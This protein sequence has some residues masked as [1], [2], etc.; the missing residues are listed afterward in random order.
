MTT[1]ANA[2]EI[3]E[4]V[5]LPH[6]DSKKL[7]GIEPT[8]IEYSDMTNDYAWYRL[9][10]KHDAHLGMENFRDKDVYI[11]YFLLSL[12]LLEYP[13]QL[14]GGNPGGGKSLY[15]AWYTRQCVRL[16][17]KKATL[18]WVPPRPEL[19]GDFHN[20]Y[21]QDFIDEIM[22]EFDRLSILEKECGGRIPQEEL[23]KLILYNA[24][25]GLEE[26]DSYLHRQMQTNLTRLIAMIGRRRRHTFTSISAVLIN[27]NE[28]APVFLNLATH[29]VNCIWEGHYRDTCSILI[30]DVRKGGTGLAKWLWLRPADWE[31]LWYS[32]NIPPLTHNIELH[33]GNTGK[34]DREK[35]RRAKEENNGFF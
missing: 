18:D 34:V 19:F 1:T 25:F 27:I 17:K 12:G 30:Q 29:K 28:F 33:F 15:E 11:K 3:P 4:A 23:E 6:G 35:R 5:I 13:V 20:L 16:F 14:I 22:D 31:G 2:I 8:I 26:C 10:V 7:L 21:D 24:A 32:H 9:A